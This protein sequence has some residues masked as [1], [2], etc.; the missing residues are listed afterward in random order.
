MSD[1]IF[2]KD[3]VI[4]LC[5]QVLDIGCNIGHIT[6]CIAKTHSPARIVGVDIDKKLV[7]IAKKNIRYYA[8]TRW[9]PKRLS[10]IEIHQSN[11][12]SKAGQLLPEKMINLY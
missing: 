12:H 5:V 4:N 8:D 1:L 2:R 9:D 10:N 7:D 3:F 11:V 6:T